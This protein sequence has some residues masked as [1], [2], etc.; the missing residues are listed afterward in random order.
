[1]AM[2][3]NCVNK[4]FKLN[5][6][7]INMEKTHYLQFKTKNKPTCNINIV[8]NEN[9]VTALPEIKFLSIYIQDS[10]NWNCHIDYIIP[11]LS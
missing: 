11:K 1:M 3:F 5:L 10:I 2:V 4:W 6:L 8:C 7:S 9:L